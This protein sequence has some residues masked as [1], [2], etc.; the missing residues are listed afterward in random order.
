MKKKK[1][2][3]NMGVSMKKDF[4][5]LS[6]AMFTLGKHVAALTT[7]KWEHTETLGTPRWRRE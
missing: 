1:K 7:V 4:R 5:I 3:R 6:F 2:K